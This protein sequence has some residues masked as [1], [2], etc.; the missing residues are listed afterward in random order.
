MDFTDLGPAMSAAAARD[1]NKKGDTLELRVAVLEE[2]LNALANLF[3]ED[4]VNRA[5][6]SIAKRGS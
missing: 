6:A 4:R 2:R 5:W 1:A 3:E